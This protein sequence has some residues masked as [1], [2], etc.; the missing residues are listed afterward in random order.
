MTKKFL[1]ATVACLGFMGSAQAGSIIGGLTVFGDSYF[2]ATPAPGTVEFLSSKIL[3]PTI[4][5]GSFTTLGKPLT[6]IWSNPGIDIPADHLGI[7]SNYLPWCPNCLLAFNDGVRGGWLD[8]TSLKIEPTTPSATGLVVDG[9][10]I[11]TLNYNGF[12]PTP[13]SWRFTENYV[14]AAPNGWWAQ[15]SFVADDPAQVP[16]PIVGA[17]LPGL[18]S[19]AFGM[20]ML[21]R[22][23]RQQAA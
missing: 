6:L 7:G 2:D 19:A 18:V 1:L 4:A 10:G 12:D 20:V 9:R 21:A 13:G 8:I 5:T 11:M 17:G 23:R 14:S 16:G 3:L 22:R 15:L